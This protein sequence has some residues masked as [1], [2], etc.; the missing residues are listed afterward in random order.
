MCQSLILYDFECACGYTHEYLV[1]PTE[2][3]PCP[4]C[5]LV[6]KRCISSPRL[7]TTIIPT[8]PGSKKLKA[9]YE[10]RYINRPATKTQVGYGG[11]TS[12]NN[13]KK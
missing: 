5:H 12:T 11:S 8:Y 2:N 6:M 9:G 13:P 3:V 10:H 4:L 1:T 7:F